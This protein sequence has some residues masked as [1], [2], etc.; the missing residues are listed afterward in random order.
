MWHHHGLV[1]EYPDQQPDRPPEKPDPNRVWP[2]LT[3]GLI[4]L[5]CGCGSLMG[6][7][8]RSASGQPSEPSGGPVETATE[9]I[10][11]FGCLIGG[12]VCIG[13]AIAR[14]SRR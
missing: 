4:L 12:L 7:A 5:F 9:M 1:S 2:H 11:Q 13:I 8:T 3:F 10:I 6:R 14:L